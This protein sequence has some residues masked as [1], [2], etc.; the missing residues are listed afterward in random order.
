MLDNESGRGVLNTLPTKTRGF[1]LIELMIGIVIFAMAMAMGIPSYRIWTQNTQIRNAAESIQNGLQRARN[2]A[3]K[4]NTAVRF[5]LLGT[6]PAWASSWEI[7]IVNPAETVESR[8]GN[9][10]SKNATSKGFDS[11]GAGANTVT[12][13]SF[14][15][16][17][18]ANP[19]RLIQLDSAQLAA[20]DSRNLEVR[21][22]VLNAGIWAG[23]TVKMCDPNLANGTVGAC[24]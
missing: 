2:E 1:T 14:G 10:G 12:F 5:V 11:A 22:G 15:M 21:I 9:E 23:S 3:V 4:R 13:N 19:L 24:Q 16:V 18:G 17:S 7:D 20:A 8:S 6:S